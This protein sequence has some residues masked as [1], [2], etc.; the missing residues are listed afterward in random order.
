M[1]LIEWTKKEFQ[2]GYGGYMHAHLFQEAYSIIINGRGHFQHN[3]TAKVPLE[4]FHVKKGSRYRFRLVN[5]GV[6][7]CFLE[8]SVDGHDLTVIA[9]DGHPI[10]PIVVSSLV[11]SNGKEMFFEY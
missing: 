9:T 3:L 4:T 1:V 7:Y 6:R 10:E 2:S 5:S 11:S 8:L